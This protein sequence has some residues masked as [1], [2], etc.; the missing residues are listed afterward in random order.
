M[1]TDK[2]LLFRAIET[3]VNIYV[4]YLLLTELKFSWSLIKNTRKRYTR[5]VKLKQQE[6][7]YNCVQDY[8]NRRIHTYMP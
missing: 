6:N 2:H 4:V 3:T 8:L 7:G 1:N 5:Y